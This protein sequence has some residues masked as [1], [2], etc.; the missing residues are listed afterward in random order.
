MTIG[1]GRAVAVG[2]SGADLLAGAALCA[3]K[4]AGRAC[5]SGTTDA[6]PAPTHPAP[7]LGC[8]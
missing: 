4:R 3:A 7:L 6:L 1:V 5:V 2:R 8:A